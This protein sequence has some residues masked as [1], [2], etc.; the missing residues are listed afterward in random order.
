MKKTIS[1]WQFAGFAFTSFT[2]TILH[3]L[4]D[5]TGQN[6]FIAPFS[7]VNESTWEHMKLL[8]FPLLLFALI[9]SRFLRKS[10]PNF[11]CVKWLGITVGLICIPVLFYTYN[12]AFGTS[13]DFVNIAIFFIS[14]AFVYLLETKLF[15][16]DFLVC[17]A[18]VIPITA[19]LFIAV[20]FILFTFITP[21]IPLFQDP[22]TMLYG[23]AANRR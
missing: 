11:W 4:Y 22:I 8:F 7:G 19:L 5:W 14:A 18:S 16:K 10:V 20:L 9:E 6:I 3:F 21:E 12:G 2:G 15:Q 23:I 1:L 17:R 13:P